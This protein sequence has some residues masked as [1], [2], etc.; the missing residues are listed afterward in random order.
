M[1]VKLNALDLYTTWSPNLYRFPRATPEEQRRALLS[2]LIATSTRETIK[3][4]QG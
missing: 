1:L 4:V 2:P 3:E